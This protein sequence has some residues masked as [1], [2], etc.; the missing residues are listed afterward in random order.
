MIFLVASCNEEYQYTSGYITGTVTDAAT[1]L[2]LKDCNVSVSN[3]AGD[4]VHSLTT[5]EDG[6]YKTKDIEA[7][8]YTITVEKEYYI[9]GKNS[10][11]V[12]VVAGETTKC[13]ISLGR[14]PAKITSDTEELDFGA[15]AS[16][17]T[18]SFKIVNKYLDD[19]DWIVEYDCEWIASI[20]PKNDNLA[21]GKTA[22]IIV[23]ID[24]DKLSS[25]DNKTNIVVKSLNGQGGL[26]IS[27]KAIG[28][29][30]EAASVNIIEATDIKSSSAVLHGRITNPGTP[31]YTERGFYYSK[32]SIDPANADGNPSV[33]K[34]SCP[35]DEKEDYSYTVSDLETDKTYFARAYVVNT[36]SKVV[37]SNVITFKPNA[38]IP[39]VSISD[40][41]GLDVS[42]R[43]AV[44]NGTVIS[45]G[46]PIF[47]EKG[48]V[49]GDSTAPTIYDNKIAVE[50]QTSGNYSA[51][52][53]NLLFDRTYY[54]RAYVSQRGQTYY[55]SETVSFTLSKVPPVLQMTEVTEQAYSL[56]QAKVS[57]QV[58]SAGEP[59]YTKRGFVY[60]FN[61][62]PTVDNSRFTYVTGN[63]TGAFS[64]YLSDLYQDRQYFVRSFAEQEGNVVYSTNELEFT[65]SPT[66]AALGSISVS[67]VYLDYAKVSCVVTEV[68]DPNYTEKGFI[69][70]IEGNPDIDRN[71]GKVVIDGTGPGSFNGTLSGLSA[72]QKYF[73]KAYIKQNGNVF[74]SGEQSFMTCKTTPIINT[75]AATNVA[76]NTATLN[77]TVTYTGDPAYNRRG[78]YWGEDPNPL[79]GNSTVIIENASE[80]GSF[81]SD[82]TSLSDNTTYYYRAFVIQPREST[83]SLGSI[84]SFTTGR[85]PNVTTGGVINVTCTGDN[86]SNLKWSVTMYGGVSDFGDPAYTAFG[87]VYGTPNSPSVDDGQSV[88]I[89]TSQFEYQDNARIFYT[90]V[91]G[92]ST[93][94]KYYLR[95]VATTPLGYVYGE[96]IEFTPTVIAPVLRTVST[97]CEQQADGRWAVALVG[98]AASLGQPQ[99]TGLGFVYSLSNQPTV[100]NP[101]SKAVSYTKCEKQNGYY[102]FGCATFDIEGGKNYYVRAY[103][104]TNLGYTYGEVLTFKTY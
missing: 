61:S 25:G 20:T 69:Y 83:P 89:T 65:L 95:A 59:E 60:G 49:Y 34:V 63:G 75:D 84:V 93:N 18:L 55:S 94:V 7:G 11:P 104:K 45:T 14:I 5:T 82:L 28:E 47:S 53:S 10:Q 35:V 92:L 97:Q 77:A 98:A 71:F 46:D 43:K 58:T 38:T 51:P 80:Q 62:N 27:I 52:V 40:V 41:T 3:S 99:A 87:F 102:V 78:F 22:T 12:A 54:V 66:P 101:D 17:A 74:Y 44:F 23:K 79:E 68:G 33:F 4:N 37:S 2:P 86:A 39:T 70:N 57:A 56:R 67:A 30:K 90:N 9:T 21:H 50:G 32:T 88:Y 26:N 91:S 73:V 96:P 6:I 72:N 85:K 24:R 64:L 8:T 29:F 42:G 16:L 36:I 48:F 76:Y 19:L 103:A 15:D 1:G 81:S 100:G 13:D 31:S